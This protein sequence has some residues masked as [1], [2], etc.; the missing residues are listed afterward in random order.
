MH[1]HEPGIQAPFRCENFWLLATVTL[2]F[3][4]GK[5]YPIMNYLGLK[6]SQ[7]NCAISYSFYLHLMLHAYAA[8]FD[9]TGN[10]EN[11]LFLGGI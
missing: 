9:V 6:D 2:S 11:F 7:T 5:N 10:L 1:C 4:F 3:V 8:R